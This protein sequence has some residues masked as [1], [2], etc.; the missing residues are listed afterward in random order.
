MIDA[1]R[2]TDCFRY[3]PQ[4]EKRQIREF[5][6]FPEKFATDGADV[7]R[8]NGLVIVVIRF[9][10]IST[11]SAAAFREWMHR[12]ATRGHAQAAHQ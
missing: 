11:L 12:V 2:A 10:K 8:I 3:A 4:P 9:G 6:K 7:R 5:G 1:A